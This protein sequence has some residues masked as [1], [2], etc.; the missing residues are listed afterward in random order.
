[1]SLLTAVM[2]GKAE[3]ECVKL[4]SAAIDELG[5]RADDDWDDMSENRET[6]EVEGLREYWLM[7]GMEQLRGG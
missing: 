1:M 2:V 3:S 4:G 7:V 5:F 6:L